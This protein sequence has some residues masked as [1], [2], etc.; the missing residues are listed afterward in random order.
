VPGEVED[1]TPLER[2]EKFYRL[3]V[4]SLVETHVKSWWSS[5]L[6]GQAGVTEDRIDLSVRR[7]LFEKLRLGSVRPSAPPDR[8]RKPA[9]RQLSRTFD[10]DPH[11][12]YAL[13]VARCSKT[14]WSSS[15]AEQE[16]EVLD[17]VVFEERFNFPIGGGT[18]GQ[19]GFVPDAS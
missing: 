9:R 18:V 10:R 2:V 17:R 5:S 3:A 6:V 4:T 1:L 11:L 13:A 7:L 15:P 14:R 16:E 8:P 19:P 12:K